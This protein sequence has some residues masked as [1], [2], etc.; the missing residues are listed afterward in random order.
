MPTH[1][2]KSTTFLNWLE[3]NQISLLTSIDTRALTKVLRNY[4]A[5]VFDDSIL[6]IFQDYMSTNLVATL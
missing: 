1:Y 4:G 5:I 6:T 3:Q 2:A